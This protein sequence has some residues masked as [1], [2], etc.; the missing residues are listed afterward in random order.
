MV[1]VTCVIFAHMLTYLLF[2][3]TNSIRNLLNMDIMAQL[4][5][6]KS[7]LQIAMY[8]RIYCF[9]QFFCHALKRAHLREAP[10]RKYIVTNN[11]FETNWWCGFCSGELEREREG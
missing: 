3:I 7:L 11:L 10:Y 5:A 4:S 9:L 6:S 1:T 2:E 8:L